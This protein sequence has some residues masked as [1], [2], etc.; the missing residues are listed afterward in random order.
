MALDGA[1]KAVILLQHG[2]AGFASAGIQSIAYGEYR[3]KSESEIH[4]TGYVVDS[5]EAA[6]WCSYLT[7]SFE[8]AILKAANLGQDADTTAAICGQVAGAFYGEFNIP[9]NWRKKFALH[10]EICFLADQLNQLK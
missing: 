9:E 2:M 5:L 7:D 6:L 10:D 4:G 3:T 1:S 8:E